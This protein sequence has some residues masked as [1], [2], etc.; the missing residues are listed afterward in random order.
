M[1]DS[2]LKDFLILHLVLLVYSGAALLS[3]AAA[4][5]TGIKFIFCYGAVLACLGVYSILWQLVLK[6]FPLTTAF[7]NKAVVVVWGILW[8]WLFFDEQ[9]TLQKLA[10]A[11]VIIVG[12]V[13]VV[14]DNEK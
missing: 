8:G 12:I 14:S 3:K 4:L 7:A 5:Q 2:K 13:I 1:R 11:A 6:R 10:G 9:I